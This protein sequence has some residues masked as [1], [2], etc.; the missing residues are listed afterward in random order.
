MRRRVFGIKKAE[1]SLVTSDQQRRVATAVSFLSGVLAAMHALRDARV[2]W[3]PDVVW[4]TLEKP[5]QL[6]LGV[7]IALI[8]VSFVV[9]I[10]T[11][12]DSTFS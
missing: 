1:Y 7:G 5:Q 10:V 6:E 12:R 9:S 3:P 2:F 11:R 8:V 4:A